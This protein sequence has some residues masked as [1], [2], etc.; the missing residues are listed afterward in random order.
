MSYLGSIQVTWD[1][2]GIIEVDATVRDTYRPLYKRKLRRYSRRNTNKIQNLVI[3]YNDTDVVV[4]LM[5]RNYKPVILSFPFSSITQGSVVYVSFGKP[6]RNH[7]ALFSRA[8]KF[9]N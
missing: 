1:T 2:R 4:S 7:G 9:L 8:S 3:N 5:M 6:L